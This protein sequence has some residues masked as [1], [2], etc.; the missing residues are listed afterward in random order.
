MELMFPFPR[1]HGHQLLFKMKKQLKI[2][3]PEDIKTIITY[4]SA[5]LSAKYPVKTKQILK[6]ETLFT[7]SNS[8][9][10]NVKM[11]ILAKQTEVL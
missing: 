9:T 6:D 5:K 1:K 3:L 10:K 11:V 4:K 2:T 8:Q 7:I